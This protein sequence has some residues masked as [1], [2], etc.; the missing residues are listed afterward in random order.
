[1]SLEAATRN[2]LSSYLLKTAVSS[3]SEEEEG[4]LQP[5][6]SVCSDK[7]VLIRW[8]IVGLDSDTESEE[9]LQHIAKLW[10]TVRGFSLTK[11][12]MEDYKV[13]IAVTTQKKNLRKQLKQ[14]S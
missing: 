11:A 12:W 3:T 14:S 6:R 9:L 1:L 5:V 8:T 4:V 7:N 2:K 10:I 13:S